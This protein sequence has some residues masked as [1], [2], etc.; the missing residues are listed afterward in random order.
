MLIKISNYFYR[1]EIEKEWQKPEDLLKKIYDE[2]DLP[3]Y[4]IGKDYPWVQLKANIIAITKNYSDPQDG[5]Y[6]IT[7]QKWIYGIWLNFIDKNFDY[8]AVVGEK[9]TYWRNSGKSSTELEETHYYGW[10]KLWLS[11]DWKYIVWIISIPRVRDGITSQEV[12]DLLKILFEKIFTKPWY[13]RWLFPAYSEWKIM[14]LFSE[15]TEINFIKDTNVS[16]LIWREHKKKIWNPRVSVKMTIKW[17]E[18]TRE[19][20]KYLSELFWWTVKDAEIK[21]ELTPLRNFSI[22]TWKSS[23]KLDSDELKMN[24]IIEVTDYVYTLAI[25]ERWFFQS[26]NILFIRN[27]FENFFS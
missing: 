19:W 9:D 13:Y 24:N 16:D 3:K 8:T 17:L 6:W 20:W 27:N 12:S 4:R 10:L 21:K 26:N 18:Q 2:I 5:E 11:E 25:A 15:S 1:F 22:K 14:K 7:F 23:F